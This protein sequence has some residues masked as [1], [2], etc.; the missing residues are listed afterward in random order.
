MERD[1]DQVSRI[2]EPLS[3]WSILGKECVSLVSSR[4]RGGG[5]R[6]DPNNGC[7]GD[8]TSLYFTLLYLFHSNEANANIVHKL[9]YDAKN[10]YAVGNPQNRNEI[11]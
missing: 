7:E 3:H 1:L 4:Y 6:D 2:W 5:L 10:K 11:S 8:F 9:N